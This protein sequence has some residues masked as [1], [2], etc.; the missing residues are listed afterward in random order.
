M[1]RVVW[2][3]SPSWGP[4]APTPVRT[5]GEPHRGESMFPHFPWDPAQVNA[6]WCGQVGLTLERKDDYE[7]LQAQTRTWRDLWRH[8]LGQGEQGV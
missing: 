5:Q 3:K 1:G 6:H 4:L 8:L 7:G 2:E